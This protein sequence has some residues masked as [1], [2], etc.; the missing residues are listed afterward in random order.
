MPSNECNGGFQKAA[1]KTVDGRLMF[2][3]IKG[4]AIMDSDN[5]QEK[6]FM[7]N[8]VI[9]AVYV[10]GERQELKEKYE[11]NPKTTKIKIEYTAPAFS[12]PEKINFRHK[13]VGFDSDWVYAGKQRSTSIMNLTPGTYQFMV[14]VSDIE[15]N[16]STETAAIELKQEPCFSSNDLV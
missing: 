13:L 6:P 10:D 14:G 2:P 4:I 15:G 11:L 12:V 5:V 8:P 7:P 16:W 9:T 3:T 1:L